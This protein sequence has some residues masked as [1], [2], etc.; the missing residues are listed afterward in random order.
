MLYLSELDCVG[1]Q[2]IYSMFFFMVLLIV[3]Y[4]IF[5][6]VWFDMDYK[7]MCLDYCLSFGVFL[8]YS[9]DFIMEVYDYI[10]GGF[11]NFFKLF[12]VK[13]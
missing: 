11:C 12:F 7:L 13:K 3:L 1:I 2:V 8:Y 6:Q 9:N 4:V 5:V 10:I